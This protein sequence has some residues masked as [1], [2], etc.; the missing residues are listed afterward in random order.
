MRPAG[1]ARSKD[2]DTPGPVSLLRVTYRSLLATKGSK[3]AHIYAVRLRR[4]TLQFSWIYVICTCDEQFH[5]SRPVGARF[6]AGRRTPVADRKAEASASRTGK[7]RRPDALPDLH[8]APPRG[9][10]PRHGVESRTR[11]GDASAI[12]EFGDRFARD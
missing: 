11:R 9:G 2:L 1:T 6:R 12:D 4:L 8:P 10:W 3:V 5:G 7:S